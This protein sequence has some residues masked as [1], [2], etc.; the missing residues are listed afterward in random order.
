MNEQATLAQPARAAG[1]TISLDEILGGRAAETE[2][3]APTQTFLPSQEA[4]EREIS[5]VLQLELSDA[6]GDWVQGYSRV[7]H[8]NAFLWK[9]CRRGVG[10]TTL[11]CV[12]DDLRNTVCDTKVLG[13]VLDVLLDDVADN[14]QD[15]ALL[16]AILNGMEGRSDPIDPPL[17]TA[18]SAYARFTIDVWNEI[19][20]RVRTFPR[21]GEFSE[22][23]RFDY[24]QLF[25]VMRYSRLVNKFP[26]MLNL[27]EH[28]LYLPHN[29]HM[30]ISSTMD[31]MCSGG[32]DRSELGILREAVWRAQCM[33]RVGN[34]VTT[35]QRE[36]SE[37]DFTSAVFAR[38][39][40]CRD[41][42]LDDLRS[43][44][45]S[46]IEE[47]I[48]GRRHEE[49]F[50]NRWQTYRQEILTLQARCRSVN[51]GGLIAGLERLICL[52][53]GSRGKK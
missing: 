13:V 29:M 27:A 47:V 33:G 46:R 25:N 15:V 5:A 31:C 26:E 23:L 7:G 36:I 19:Q 6:L 30:M 24:Q 35:W 45:R 49:F 9:W 38:A 52:H 37:G 28:D 42:S 18:E 43:D 14:Q 41:L 8:R 16:E 53:L 51:L 32:F 1:A 34:L 39:L 48:V 12:E 11:S 50:L 44:N 3:A 20:R 22:V 40:L 2:S 21:Y 10:V 4:I 17:S